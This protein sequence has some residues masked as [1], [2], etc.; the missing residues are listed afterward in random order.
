MG[1][2][3]KFVEL[4]DQAT[5]AEVSFLQIDPERREITRPSSVNATE[6]HFHF[7]F[8][9]IVHHERIQLIIV[10]RGVQRIPVG[11]DFQAQITI[12]LPLLKH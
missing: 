4:V 1:D 12:L 10:F 7:P 8:L 6:L 11:R 5:V 2:H 3:L 9:T